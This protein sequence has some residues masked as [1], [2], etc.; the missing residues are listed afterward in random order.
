MVSLKMRESIASMLQ[1][2]R[3]YDFLSNYTQNFYQTP[4]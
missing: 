2:I 4:L 1:E 3:A